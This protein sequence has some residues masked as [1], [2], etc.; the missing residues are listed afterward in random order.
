MSTREQLIKAR[1]GMLALADELKNIAK[2]CRLA[3]VS[4][5]HLYEIKEAYETFGR[6]G[7][8]PKVRRMAWMPNQTPPSWRGRSWP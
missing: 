6:E 4:R 8:G 2:A 1:L 3:G 5:S 7:L